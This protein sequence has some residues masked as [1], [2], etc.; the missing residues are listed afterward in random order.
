MVIGVH[1]F[2]LDGCHG[3]LNELMKAHG[4]VLHELRSSETTAKE[5]NNTMNKVAT[6]AASYSDRFA[7]QEANFMQFQNLYCLGQCSP[8]LSGSDCYRCLVGVISY[9]PSGKQGG[10]AFNPSCNVRF[11][12]Y[13]FYG[14]IASVPAPSPTLVS[15]LPLT[16]P[17]SSPAFVSSPPPPPGD[18][19]TIP[20]KQGSSSRKII[21]IVVPSVAAG[22]ILSSVLLYC[23]IIQKKEE[24][25]KENGGITIRSG[26]SLQFDFSTVLVATNNFADI[27][28]IGQGGFGDVYMGILPNEQEIAIKR[29]S[30]NSGQGAEEFKNEVVLVAKLQHRNLV[31]L[32]GFCLEGEEKILIYES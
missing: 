30:R 22:L 24:P 16:K 6:E 29:L 21:T 19:T 18:G 23:L 27:N 12:M 7:T 2:F 17:A 4:R 20:G 10:R 26:E 5:Y 11:E 13:S 32:L 15:P 28:K 31:R 8:D 9:L 1:G 14:V 3:R 25:S